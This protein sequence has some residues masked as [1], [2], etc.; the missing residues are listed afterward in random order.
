MERHA[1][2]ASMERPWSPVLALQIVP[3]L[4]TAQLLALE[5]DLPLPLEEMEPLDNPQPELMDLL[6][7]NWLSLYS[8]SLP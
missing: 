2:F 5:M 3:P 8:D 7:T 4:V 1:P 6:P